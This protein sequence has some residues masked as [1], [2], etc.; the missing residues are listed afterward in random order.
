MAYLEW[1]DNYS[2]GIKAMDDHHKKLFDI[3]NELHTGMSS[4]STDETLRKVLSELTDYTKY[5]F[6]EEENL[7][8]KYDYPK[9]SSQKKAHDKL[10]ETLQDLQ[11][12]FDERKG[13]MTVIMK[14]QD[15]L[16]SWLLNHIIGS[17]K[18]YGPYLNSKGIE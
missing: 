18:K 1:N 8:S 14:M 11:Q 17:D 9:L 2:V 3:V 10:I 16:R 7:M 6:T 15:F 13:E 4:G 12:Q 5:H